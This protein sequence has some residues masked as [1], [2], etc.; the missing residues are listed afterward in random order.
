M[1]KI[2]LFS[3]NEIATFTQKRDFWLKNSPILQNWTFA[4]EL[5]HSKMTL[6]GGF[7]S[8]WTRPQN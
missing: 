6:F 7:C 4:K 3:S 8:F 5:S 1:P 2:A